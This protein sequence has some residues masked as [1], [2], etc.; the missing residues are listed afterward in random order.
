MKITKHKVPSVTYSLMVE[1]ELVDQA[2]DDSPLVYLAGVGQMIPGFEKELEGKQAGDDFAFQ[3]TSDVAY[4]D[5]NPD[6][7]VDLSLDIFKVDGEV[8]KE[9]IAVGN[10]VP[11]QDNEGNPLQGKVLEIGDENV[12]MDFNHPLAGKELNFT[13]KIVDVRDAEAEEI[14][15]GHVHGAGGHQH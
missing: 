4:G 10:F 3:L 11:M 9:I 5:V 12:K 8:N 14:E 13:G 15:H 6:A 2:M 1:G 7:I